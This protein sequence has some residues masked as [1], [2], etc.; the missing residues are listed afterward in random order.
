M[1]LPGRHRGPL[2]RALSP[3]SRTPCPPKPATRMRR[4]MSSTGGHRRRPLDL[5]HLQSEGACDVVSTGAENRG[6]RSREGAG[7]GAVRGCTVCGAVAQHAERIGLSPS[8]RAPTSATSTAD[9]F[10]MVGQGERISTREKP[11]PLTW[12]STAR[13]MALSACAICLLSPRPTRA[14]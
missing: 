3:G 5:T 9:I 12:F 11:R 6:M 7:W 1:K 4:S 13:R 10:Q 14:M 2:R 8:R